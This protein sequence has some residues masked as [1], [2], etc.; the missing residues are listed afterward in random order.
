MNKTI[1]II[2]AAVLVLAIVIG[3][4]V[5]TNKKEDKPRYDLTIQEVTD[6]KYIV[7]LLVHS[8]I[9]AND[10]APSFGKSSK[11]DRQP[12]KVTNFKSIQVGAELYKNGST[13][14][15]ISEIEDDHITVLVYSGQFDHNGTKLKDNSTFEVK[16]GE[17][18]VLVET[19]IGSN[20][21]YTIQ[22]NG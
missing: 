21:V 11:N 6:T 10:G 17:N 8:D 20:K 12:D 4:F 18:E 7:Q 22:Y 1:I 16:A 14:L 5:L 2:I 13:E 9:V 3:V 19:A 15:R